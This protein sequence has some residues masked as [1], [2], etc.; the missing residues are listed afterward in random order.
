MTVE[1]LAR[2]IKKGKRRHLAKAITLTESSRSEDQEEALRLLELLN[3]NYNTIRVGISGVPGVGKST[4][5]EALGNLLVD[6]GHKVAVLAV[7][8][9]SPS[10]GGSILGDKTRMETLANNEG[11]FIRPSPTAGTLGGVAK[12]TRESML[13]CEAAGYDVILIET[14]GVGQS[15]FEV[16]SMVDCF[17]VMMLPGAGDSLQ[18]IKRGIL[19]ITD[20]LVVNKA[21]GDQERLAYKAR[22]EYEQTFHLLQPKYEGIGVEFLAISALEQKGIN[23]VWDAVEEFVSSL[24]K[25]GF[26]DKIREDQNLN[27]FKRLAEDKFLKILWDTP[28]NKV[29]AKELRERI[30]NKEISPSA[31][32]EKMTSS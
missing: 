7:D 10:S 12:R 29:K 19:E 1:E 6:Q 26:F 32:A 30:I 21:D 2:G 4:F 16:A 17:L 31:A 25:K 3:G 15:E 28:E 18:G 11:A 22:D 23:K 5:I 27:W 14:V 8:P 24:K 13:L 9:S 20:I